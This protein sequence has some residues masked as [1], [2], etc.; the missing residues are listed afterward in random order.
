MGFRRSNLQEAIH[1]PGDHGFRIWGYG[2]TDPLAD[3][4][5]PGYFRAAGTLLQS[6]QLIFVSTLPRRDP[7]GAELGETRSAL[8]M[9]RTVERGVPTVRLVQDFGRPDDATPAPADS[10]AAPAN[11][12]PPPK[13]GRGRPPGSRTKPKA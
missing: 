3:L 4:L 11:P 9:V 1:V 8:V 13:R 2:T 6:G 10:A 12:P 7:W 5:S